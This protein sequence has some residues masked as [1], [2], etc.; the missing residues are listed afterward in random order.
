[1]LNVMHAHD[2]MYL[3]IVRRDNNGK[4][5]EGLTCAVMNKDCQLLTRIELC[6]KIV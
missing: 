3:D 5:I 4:L 6:E 1:M 2:T